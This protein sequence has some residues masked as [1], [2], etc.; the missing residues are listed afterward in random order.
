MKL[1]TTFVIF[2]ALSARNL[3]RNMHHQILQLRKERYIQMMPLLTELVS[4]F[5]FELQICR[6][7]GALKIVK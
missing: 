3:C 2:L 1:V 4:Q 7:A 6:A 5:D